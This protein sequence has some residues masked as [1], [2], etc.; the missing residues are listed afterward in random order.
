MNFMG[1]GILEISVIFLVAF[2][3]MGPAKT[4]EMARTTGR[5]LRD[6]RKVFNE[7]AASV[8][9]GGITTPSDD[10]TGSNT[11]SNTGGNTGGN[12]GGDGASNAVPTGTNPPDSVPQESP[13]PGEQNDR[14]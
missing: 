6:V 13:T 14:T 4:I 12:A 2:L 5:V 9:L 10:K 1:M 7:M 3:V 8:D 11:G